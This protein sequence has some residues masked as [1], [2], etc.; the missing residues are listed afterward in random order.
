VA[1]A[2]REEC[3]TFVDGFVQLEHNGR[4]EALWKLCSSAIAEDRLVVPLVVGLALRD[5]G[6]HEWAEYAFRLIM[7]IPGV[8][9]MATFELAV[10]K[11]F[12]GQPD[13]AVQLLEP[14]TVEPTLNAYHR[15]FFSHQLTRVG[16]RAEAEIQLE[17][18]LDLDLAHVQECLAIE[19]FADYLAEF[20]E[21]DALRR[22]LALHDSYPFRTDDEVVD[23]FSAA[24][25]EGR[26]WSL[27]RINDGEGATFRFP[28][29]DEARFSELYRWSRNEFHKI[30]FGGGDMLFDPVYLAALDEFAAT[31]PTAD[32][33][34]ADHQGSLT[35]EYGIGSMRNVPGIFNIVRKLEHLLKTGVVTPGR[36][37][38][39]SPSINQGLLFSGRL[40]EIIGAQSRLGL[41]GPYSALPDRLARRFDLSEVYFHKTPGEAAVREGPP[42]P[43]E[44][45]HG[46]L[47][48]EMADVRPGVLYLVAAGVT[49][50]TYCSLIKQAGGVAFDIGSVADIWMGKPTRSFS[51]A[52]QAHRLPE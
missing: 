12:Q 25:R 32:C 42:E 31:I 36:I 29:A 22:C 21:A 43:M 20:P 11:A 48:A 26:G 18:S 15:R 8:G 34:A 4:L 10:L 44:V 33:L 23:D 13:L 19:Q 24:L 38:L 2:I 28:I 51:P 46:R 1:D 3:E 49:G 5:R 14:P 16:R 30:W 9:G 50:K 35:F 17:R 37:N 41:I 39:C 45:W 7:P 47:M 27:I 40:D 52:A 6:V